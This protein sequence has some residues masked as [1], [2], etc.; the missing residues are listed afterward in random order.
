MA[1]FADNKDLPQK[2]KTAYDFFIAKGLSPQASA[3]IVGNLTAESM[4][5][6]SILGDNNRSL[7][8]AQWMGER[9]TNLKKKY[10]DSYKTFDGQLNY[11]WDEL[12]TTHKKALAKL[13][14]A[15]DIESATIAFQD[16]FERPNK[17]YAHTDN[18]IK[19]A[20]NT[21]ALG[22]TVE[23]NLSQ[24]NNFI[25]NGMNMQTQPEQREDVQA[26][27]TMMESLKNK[28]NQYNFVQELFSQTSQNLTPEI[29]QTQ[30]PNIPL[31][32]PY[33]GLLGGRTI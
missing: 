3:G 22:G 16:E 18:R 2:Q 30:T 6:T 19:F 4:L 9:Q 28:I 33:E 27:D 15:Q 10:P 12:N 20:R 23:D 14:T 24:A 8:I 17:K 25:S 1:R 11:I 29:P 7:G 26:E 31:I 5:N 32:D 13:Q 21:I